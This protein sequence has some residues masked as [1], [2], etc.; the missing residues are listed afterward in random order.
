MLEARRPR[1]E[2]KCYPYPPSKLDLSG[3]KLNL[4]KT[5]TW[6]RM[7]KTQSSLE[8]IHGIGHAAQGAWAFL[9]KNKDRTDVLSNSKILNLQRA[10]Q[11]VLNSL[12]VI[13]K[14][15]VMS[16]RKY[17]AV[18]TCGVTNLLSYGKVLEHTKLLPTPTM[19]PFPRINGQY[20]H[21]PHTLKMVLEYYM[22]LHRDE[23]SDF[24]IDWMNRPNHFQIAFGGDGAPLGTTEGPVSCLISVINS[25]SRMLSR[26]HN[27][28][29]C[30]A[31]TSKENDD[32]LIEYYKQVKLWIVE[33][34]KLGYTL[35]DGTK[36][37]A[38]FELLPADQKFIA[39]LG[40]ELSDAATYPSSFSN[41]HKD[42]CRILNPGP[43][44][45]CNYPNRLVDAS[46]V[47]VFKS[48]VS[49]NRTKVT[50]LI[51]SLKSRQEFSSPNRPTSY[52]KQL[53]GEDKRS[54]SH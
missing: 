1:N 29:V 12:K 44:T 2:R 47:E 21:L 34:E 32:D 15:G 26:D 40:G 45:P 6:E 13:Y 46:K 16:K 53:M 33:I 17:M 10:D 28:L 42:K 19:F 30:L 22:A 7:K 27:F 25:G 8:G 43:I 35:D 11:T 50:K 4:S 31:G 38:S 24:Q 49:P 20:C 5:Q 9:V 3:D 41:I 54:D 52:E 51:S 18:R 36:V 39:I 37:T 23:T 14:G 48:V